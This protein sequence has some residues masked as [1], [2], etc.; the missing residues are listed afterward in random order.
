MALTPL[1]NEAGRKAAKIID[2][3]FQQNEVRN[4][5]LFL[6]TTEISIFL[7]P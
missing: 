5:R 7:L 3:K 6:L 1:L 2:N 4:N